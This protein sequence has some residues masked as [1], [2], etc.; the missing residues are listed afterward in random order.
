MTTEFYFT[1]RALEQ[2]ELPSKRIRFRDGGNRNSVSGLLLNVTPTG[3]RTFYFRKKL[4]GKDVEVRLGEFPNMTVESARKAAKEVSNKF[5]QGI[6]PN[7][8]KQ[9]RKDAL[10]FDDLFS[11]YSQSFLLD[12]KA[13]K[14]RES[15]F[16]QSER[17]YRLH[18]KNLVGS[19]KIDTF[20]M[21]HAKQLLRK[22][23][24]EKGY[25][26]HNHCL[27]V[28]KS[29]F[30]RSDV[31]VNPFMSLSKV[32][33]SLH[34]RERTLNREELQRLFDSLGYEKQI[35]QDVVMLLLLTGQRKQCVLSMEWKEI[36]RDMKTWVIPTSK[37][38][39]KKPH[40]VPLSD[41][42]MSILER[43][44]NEA[45]T[46][47]HYVFPSITA[48]GHL[49]E[50]T[51]QGGFWRRIIERAGLYDPT[52]RENNVRIHDLR[53]TVATMQVSNGGSLQATSKLLGH[54]SVGITSDVYA[55][56]AVDN[57]RH[58]LEKTTQMI[59]GK[60]QSLER[61]KQQL[62]ELCATDRQEIIKYLQGV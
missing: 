54:S 48:S 61:L 4:H 20:T 2:L 38:K 31:E 39:N 43:R 7:L 26:H 44:S 13:K 11:L 27:T 25:A 15:S 49:S 46:G 28:L 51:S 5:D 23:L 50:K 9:Q 52:S 41:E 12:I 14:R 6:D 18:L 32:D 30:N 62:S 1:K 34:R 57:V 42:V 40:V 53:R 36:N 16:K 35:Y 17:I 45:V 19:L 60:G 47:E 21:L 33:E 22:I 56:L 59:L 37:I 55:H 3:K 24:S 29:M 10:T 58:E 8:E